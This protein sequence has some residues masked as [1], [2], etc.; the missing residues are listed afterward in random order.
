LSDKPN[1]LVILCGPTGVGKSR[2]AIALAGR[3]D[4][5]IVNADSMQVYRGFDIGTDKVPAGDRR[6][7]PHHLLDIA[8]A[9]TQFTA[10][11][12][13]REAL[14]AARGIIERNRIPIVVGGTGL[15]LKALLD[16]LFPGPGRL[17]GLRNR[18][19]AEAASGGVESLWQRLKAVDPEYAEKV[20]P[21]DRIRIIRALEVFE[22]TR[23]PFSR[24]FPATES[25]VKG[26]LLIRV[27]L[28]LDRAR[29]VRRIAERVDG[30]FANGIV[31]EVRSL[32]AR[33]IPE[34]APPF[35]ALGYKHVLAYIQGALTLSGAVELTKTETRQYAKRQMTWFRKMKEIAWFPADDFEAL[36][37]HVETQ[38]S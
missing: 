5:E 33:G 18:L 1:S 19:E 35:R 15:Y 2:A 10:A 6:G 17:P 4:G 16:G 12:F 24:H 37:I 31:E 11:D 29:L 34:D 30:M 26:F 23:I 28:Q 36:A 3:V 8:E 13:V 9:T 27:G 22:S 20:G 32:I 21:R 14:A 38:L 7:I 25:P